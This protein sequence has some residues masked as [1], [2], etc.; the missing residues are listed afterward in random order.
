MGDRLIR[1]E[2]SESTREAVL[3]M[4]EDAG[5][6]LVS[7]RRVPG[8]LPAHA[9]SPLH[10][11]S[12]CF[13]ATPRLRAPVAPFTGQCCPCSRDT[14]L[15]SEGLLQHSLYV[16]CFLSCQQAASG[17]GVTVSSPFG[18]QTN[19]HLLRGALHLLSPVAISSLISHASEPRLEP[20]ESSSQ[21]VATLVSGCEDTH[22]DV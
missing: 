15:P 18:P 8:R 5:A 19:C 11:I 10:C 9:H 3:R 1:L 6:S 22:S 17:I 12:C 16:H 2:S 14:A 7:A 13:C 21:R 20:A 4:K